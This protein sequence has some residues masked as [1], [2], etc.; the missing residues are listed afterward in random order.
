MG[1]RGAAE[2]VAEE[3]EAGLYDR[4]AVLLE[5]SIAVHSNEYAAYDDEEEEYPSTPPEDE[6]IGFQSTMLQD[7][8]WLDGEEEQGDPH[9]PCDAPGRSLTD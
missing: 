4:E 6:G 5:D 9:S 8:G 7:G 1:W 3:L 2:E